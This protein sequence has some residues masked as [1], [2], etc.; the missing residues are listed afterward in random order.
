MNITSIL[1]EKF[2]DYL[3]EES[4][5]A[6]TQTFEEAVNQAA[7]QRRAEFN[8]ETQALI[9]QKA[10]ELADERVSLQIDATIL[11]LDEDHSAK[12]QHLLESIDNDHTAKLQQLVEAIDIDHTN[13]LKN[14]LRVIDDKHS[15]MLEQVIEKYEHELTKVASTYK[16][17]LTEDISNFIELYIDKLVPQSQ[18]DEA[19]KNI[20][21]RRI[22]D[23][24]R[25]IVSI[26][27]NFINNEIKEALVDGKNTIDS[28]RNELNEAVNT[29]KALSQK[30]N[31]TESALLLENKTKSLS[32]DVRRHV[33]RLLKDKPVDYIKENYQYVVEMFEKE[34]RIQENLHIDEVVRQ[35]LDES[36][37]D[38]P[39]IEVPNIEDTIVPSYNPAEAVG[40]TGYLSEMKRLSG[41]YSRTA[42]S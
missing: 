25:E 14:V 32:D 10:N 40:V 21:A 3:S 4:L 11:K 30:L 24:V 26:D 17:Q 8:E 39:E 41:K 38:R 1:Q 27:E 34:S 7:E 12:L 28:L 6:I 35:R 23:Q 13:K 20:Q 42:N 37:V 5:N 15:V 29:N 2:K 22:L 33:K 16:E 19:T 9:E 31:G 18:I 36:I